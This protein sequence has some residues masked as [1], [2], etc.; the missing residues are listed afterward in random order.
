MKL[1]TNGTVHIAAEVAQCPQQNG[2]QEIPLSIII[3]YCHQIAC[4]TKKTSINGL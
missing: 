2:I 3:V 4:G 1:D